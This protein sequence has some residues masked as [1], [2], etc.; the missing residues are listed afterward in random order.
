MKVVLFCG[1]SAPVFV[2]AE[3]IPKPMV[4][5][6]QQPILWHLMQYY[7]QYGHRRFILYLG[8]KANVVKDYFLSYKQTAASDCIISD[9]G[10]RVEILGEP[11]P[12]WRVSLVDTGPWRNIGERLVAVRHL[13][14]GRRYLSSELQRWTDRR[15][16][17]RH[18]RSLQD[19]R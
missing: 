2:N 5:I 4:P 15:A 9:F 18:D 6:G 11:L 12:D 17:S 7:S 16:V 19:Q 3:S 1:G 8:Y 14:G 13:V 10:K